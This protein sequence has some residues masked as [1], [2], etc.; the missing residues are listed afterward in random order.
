MA[1][2]TPASRFV[3]VNGLRFHYLDFGGEGP[4]ALLHHATGFHGWMWAPIA[5]AL[6]RRYRVLAL[7]AR[8]H[9]DSDKPAGCYEWKQFVADLTGF[10]E[11][12]HLGRVLGVGHSLGATTTAG[13]AAERPEL[14]SA[15]VLLDPVLYPREYR[16][17]SV[18]DNPM[19]AIARRRR[20]VWNSHEQVF[21]SY[22]GRGAFAKWGDDLLRLY[23]QQGFAAFEGGV[24]LKCPPSVEAQVFG[25]DMHIDGWEMMSRVQVPTLLMR[26]AESDKLSAKDADELVRL[27]PQGLLRTVPET[28]HTFPMEAPDEVA[29][30]ILEFTHSELPLPTRGY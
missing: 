18:E 6:T 17:V 22:R 10:I 26:G 3:A 16:R 30:A 20:D 7:D 11:M 9:G 23:V 27:L 13:A 2:S 4:T 5:E 19:A 29:R 15:A 21:Q 14:F 1:L 25:M 12:L 8:G 28:T 24:R